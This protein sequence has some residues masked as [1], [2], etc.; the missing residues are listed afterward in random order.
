VLWFGTARV[1]EDRFV[2][3]LAAN[4]QARRLTIDLGPQAPD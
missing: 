2:D 1:L 4:P 3:L